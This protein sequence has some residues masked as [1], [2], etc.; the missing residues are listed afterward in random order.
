[1]SQAISTFQANLMK[2]T[3]SGTPTWERLVEIKDFPDLWS[4][5]EPLEKTTTADIM[6]TYVEGIYGNDQKNFT[7]NYNAT[8]F[9]TLQALKGQEIPVAVWFGASESGGVYT[10]DGSYGKFEGKAYV[11][12]SI[13]GKG[14]NEVVDMTVTLTM[15]EGFEPVSA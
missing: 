6:R 9:A 12:V 3:G 1:M 8:D 2:G 7:A 4:P 10:P 15:T 5:P 11:S 14:V 13:P